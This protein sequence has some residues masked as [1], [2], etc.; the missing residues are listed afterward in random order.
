M[1]HYSIST[2]KIPEHLRRYFRPKACGQCYVCHSVSFLRAIRR[3]LKP[4]GVVWW[5]ISDSYAGSWGTMSHDLEGKAKRAGTNQRPPTSFPQDGLKPLDLCLIPQRV[6]MA[7]QVDGWWVRSIVV[8]NKPNPMPES[9]SGW[10]WEKHRVKVKARGKGKSLREIELGVQDRNGG[11]SVDP[12]IWQDCPGCLRCAPHDGLVLRKGSWRPTESH[13]YIIM[14]TKSASYYG[15]GED[16]RVAHTDISLA[17]AEYENR[18]QSNTGVKSMEYGMPANIV[19]LNPAGRNLRS[20]WTF[21]TQGFD[22]EMCQSCKHIYNRRQFARLG[23]RADSRKCR[24]AEGNKDYTP[25]WQPIQ[26]EGEAEVCGSDMDISEEG[27]QCQLCGAIYTAVE[28]ETLPQAKVK[29][30]LCGESVW[31]SHFAT[32]PKELPTKCILASTSEKGCCP[33]CGAPWARVIEHKNMVIDR[34]NHAAESG[35]RIMSSGTMVEP[36]E[37]KTLSWRPT[38]QCGEKPVPAVVLDPFAGSF[39]TC[40]VAKSLGRRSIGIELSED[41][42]AIGVKRVSE[43]SLPMGV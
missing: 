26:I 38:C 24:C 16:V 13:E 43:V 14:L 33:K 30:C 3:V 40:V 21:P 36:A 25:D 1:T 34:S 2:D 28:F 6:A 20:V 8:W 18:R 29:I 15:D 42:C 23:S 5:N 39:T 11:Q 35:I 10:R 4:T 7:A 19:K 41:Y 17:R 22:L 32:F 12:A 27:Q 31:V 9:V 37:T